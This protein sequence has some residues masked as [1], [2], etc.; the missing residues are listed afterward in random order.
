MPPSP[1][2][3][4]SPASKL[5]CTPLPGHAGF[6]LQEG[7]TFINSLLTTCIHTVLHFPVPFFPVEV[8][9]VLWIPL[10]LQPR[11]E[12]L[13]AHFQMHRWVEISPVSWCNMQKYFRSI[14]DIQTVVKQRVEKREMTHTT[15]VLMLLPPSLFYRVYGK[16]SIC[17]YENI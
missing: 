6:S 15:M 13:S 12:A 2:H 16:Y 9:A 14:M 17:V 10:D 3:L 7:W 8:R 5:I 11:A 1:L 4:K